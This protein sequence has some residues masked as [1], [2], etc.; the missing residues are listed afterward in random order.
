MNGVLDLKKAINEYASTLIN[1][2]FR[3][4]IFDF[5]SI[6]S[7][8]FPIMF[9]SI[10]SLAKW[11]VIVVSFT[12]FFQTIYQIFDTWREN[13]DLITRMADSTNAI[14]D[15]TKYFSDKETK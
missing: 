4:A 6:I 1:S 5:I 12:S 9:P 14:T 10:D 7:I 15:V 3:T 2:T 13:Q 8:S 11:I